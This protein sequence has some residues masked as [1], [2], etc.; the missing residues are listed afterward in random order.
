MQARLI[1]VVSALVTAVCL[2]QTAW[3]SQ[4]KTVICDGILAGIESETNRSSPT[5]VVYDHTDESTGIL[6]FLILA[7]FGTGR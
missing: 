2:E 1:A 5:A 7:A 3:A 4:K 6:A